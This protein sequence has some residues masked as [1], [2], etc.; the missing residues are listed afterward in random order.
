MTSPELRS[1]PAQHVVVSRPAAAQAVMH[2]PVSDS[3]KPVSAA[4]RLEQEAVAMWSSENGVWKPVRILVKNTA[5][6]AMVNPERTW[7]VV[8]HYRRNNLPSGQFS[9]YKR[10]AA[11]TGSPSWVFATT[12]DTLGKEAVIAGSYVPNK[13][14]LSSYETK[15]LWRPRN[16]PF[17]I[18]IEDTQNIGQGTANV[19]PVTMISD[20]AGP[21]KAKEGMLKVAKR[22]DGALRR[23]VEA[24]R[25]ITRRNPSAHISKTLVS[26]HDSVIPGMTDAQHHY[27]A[28][29]ARERGQNVDDIWETGSFLGCET[30]ASNA[31]QYATF[32]AAISDAVLSLN[33]VKNADGTFSRAPEGQQVACSDLK[34]DNFIASLQPDPQL[35]VVPIRAVLIDKDALYA[36]E[37]SEEARQDQAVGGARC[38]I[39]FAGKGVELY[40]SAQA[41]DA[42]FHSAAVDRYHAHQVAKIAL[43]RWSDHAPE[44]TPGYA[45]QVARS[46]GEDPSRLSPGDREMLTQTERMSDGYNA[47]WIARV[48]EAEQPA[49]GSADDRMLVAIERTLGEQSPGLAAFGADMAE[50]AGYPR[51]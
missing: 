39:A 23:G 34:P 35:G 48:R 38:V 12:V 31:R 43:H 7:A 9:L 3:A 27:Y 22:D 4:H 8:P 19:L 21:R 25:I 29:D 20:T 14:F 32:M 47:R 1:K 42:C 36:Q 50:I 30:K 24:S 44:L 18:R 6:Q 16:A 40:P 49:S 10:D 37:R 33:Q 41:D 51:S 15:P 45:E 17:T 46:R 11:H 28:I 13:P 26:G 5:K 2:G